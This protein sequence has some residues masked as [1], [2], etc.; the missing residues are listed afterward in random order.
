M[1]DAW[2]PL[3]GEWL[4]ASARGKAAL[5]PRF[6]T[7]PPEMHVSQL[8]LH[9]GFTVIWTS[10]STPGV[11]AGGT[12][13]GRPTSL[14]QGIGRVMAGFY[15]VNVLK[16]VAIGAGPLDDLADMF[17]PC[18]VYTAM[19]AYA[20]LGTS[21]RARETVA[22]LL[23]Y[24]AWMPLMAMAFPDLD[25]LMRIR[26]AVARFVCIALFWA[27]HIALALVPAAVSYGAKL[28]R[29]RVPPL[30][31]GSFAQYLA[32]ANAYIGVALCAFALV[33]GR[34][35]NYSLWPPPLPARVE[36][37][38]G[39]TYY[40]VTVGLVLSFGIGPL[41]RTAYYP[42]ARAAVELLLHAKAAW[43][44]KAP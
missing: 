11:A 31:L 14:E 8:I 42:A 26:S 19:V 34:N 16:K 22:N 41:M 6:W 28:G 44:L 2:V 7:V 5:E 1:I 37:M 33:V 12:R 36:G 35:V 21:R 23:V 27:H 39:G 9:S 20:M 32:F 3:V 40:R 25:D 29:F 17:V 15:V 38:L 30:E 10:A 18:H 13:V 43:R 24:C 4:H